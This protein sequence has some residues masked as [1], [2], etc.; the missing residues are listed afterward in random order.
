MELVFTVTM[1]SDG[2]FVAACVTE[3]ILVEADDWIQLREAVRR[4]V[5]AYF[6]DQPAPDTLR[7][8]LAREEVLPL[9]G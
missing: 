6:F 1:E 2:G 8:Q 4:A 5:A 9:R 3:D 7:L